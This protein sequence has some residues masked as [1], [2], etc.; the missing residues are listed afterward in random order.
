MVQT[1]DPG[2]SLGHQ[3]CQPFPEPTEVP[4]FS[5]HLKAFAEADGK[6]NQLLLVSW[7]K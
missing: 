1:G 4:T 3:H 6:P 7:Q 5:D 2:A